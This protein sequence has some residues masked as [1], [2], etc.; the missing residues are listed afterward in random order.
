MGF[1]RFDPIG[2]P[3]NG[4]APPCEGGNRLQGGLPFL[5]NTPPR[6]FFEAVLSYW[7]EDYLRMVFKKAVNSVAMVLAPSVLG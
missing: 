2:L 4:V 3:Y 7:I 6:I 1:S 5:K